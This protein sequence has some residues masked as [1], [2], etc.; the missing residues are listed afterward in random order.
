LPVALRTLL[1]PI[2]NIALY[3]HGLVP[4]AVTFT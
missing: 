2:R 3:H 4:S 1:R